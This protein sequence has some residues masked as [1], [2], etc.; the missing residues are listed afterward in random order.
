MADDPGSDEPDPV[1]EWKEKVANL[2][3][4]AGEMQELIDLLKEDLNK[5][6]HEG[7]VAKK[8]QSRL[9]ELM[10]EDD[11]KKEKRRERLRK[12]QESKE[13][14]G[15][16]N[17]IFGIFIAC[18]LA[19]ACFVMIWDTLWTGYVEL[20]P[21]AIS[22]FVLFLLSAA[23]LPIQ[24][25]FGNHF[26]CDNVMCN[27]C[28]I[29][30]MFLVAALTLS[31]FQMYLGL[32]GW[33][34]PYL[35]DPKALMNTEFAYDP[36][37]REFN[38]TDIA[39]DMDWTFERKTMNSSSFV[40]AQGLTDHILPSSEHVGLVA[41][42]IPVVAAM[43]YQF[44]LGSAGVGMGSIGAIVVDFIDVQDFFLLLLENDIVVSYWSRP[45]E[46]NEA[47]GRDANFGKVNVTLS[48]GETHLFESTQKR[49]EAWQKEIIKGNTRLNWMLDFDPEGPYY[50]YHL[51]KCIFVY[52]IVGSVYVAFWPVIEVGL[53]LVLR[54]S[55]MDWKFAEGVKKKKRICK[56]RTRLLA[57]QAMLSLFC[58]EIP[59]F[60]LR[61][62]CSQY[63]GI[64][65]SSLF[66]KN[67]VSIVVD[68]LKLVVYFFGVNLSPVVL[69][70]QK[71]D[72]WKFRFKTMILRV[73]TIGS[74]VG[75]DFEADTEHVERL[76]PCACLDALNESGEYSEAD[77][78]D[79]DK[80]EDDSEPSLLQA[81]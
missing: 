16:R 45:K 4:D 1:E 67:A 62:A 48:N 61:F 8:S 26:D 57:I 9:E 81:R 51:W 60:T 74:F 21:Y 65:M 78:D 37:V 40:T 39:A 24:L 80:D 59:F 56:I 31:Q 25:Y 46:I 32:L 70:A 64:L 28:A 19:I 18:L 5:S 35:V 3:K 58:I 17:L 68:T 43:I 11:E 71:H 6:K 13:A 7:F 66:I 12:K 42:C 20:K 52:F 27:G 14:E 30:S 44:G 33:A 54:A 79:D 15:Q 22:V 72:K 63:Y 73:L 53:T 34:Y 2:Q 76:C 77:D 10:Q 36:A 50:N 69:Q 41:H 29:C 49:F 38:F 55:D 47:W 23:S 75:E